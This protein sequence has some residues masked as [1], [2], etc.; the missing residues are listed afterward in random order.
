MYRWGHLPLGGGCTSYILHLLCGQAVCSLTS[1]VEGLF[2]AGAGCVGDSG[3]G[4][5]LL[6]GAFALSGGGLSFLGLGLQLDLNG[7]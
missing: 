5:S 2:G 7:L 4:V 3:M 6:S 1:I